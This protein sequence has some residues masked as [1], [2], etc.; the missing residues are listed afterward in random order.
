M[1]RMN[2]DG[3]RI[4]SKFDLDVLGGLRYGS[5]V[6]IVI[7]AAVFAV[8]TAL[9]FF[10]LNKSQ[11]DVYADYYRKM[12]PG[13]LA[14]ESVYSDKSYYLLDE[15]SSDES[16][17]AAK[18]AIPPVFAID[19]TATY[20]SLE[21]ASIL[22]MA[23]VSGGDGFLSKATGMGLSYE[24]AKLAETQL[25]SNSGEFGALLV[26]MVQETSEKGVFDPIELAEKASGFESVNVTHSLDF[27]APDFTDTGFT[28]ADFTAGS[29]SLQPAKDCLVPGR[30]EAFVESRLAGSA[31]AVDAR[32][33]SA[34]AKVTA[35]IA[36]PNMRYNNLMTEKLR[37]QVDYED[38]KIY[39][40]LVPGQ[41]IVQENTI[42]TE[43][44]SRLLYLL[45]QT[46]S[47]VPK[48]RLAGSIILM[49][50]V[51]GVCLL[52]FDS[53]TRNNLHRDVLLIIYFGGSL[54]VSVIAYFM[55]RFAARTGLALF[56]AALPIYF[57][58]LLMSLLS[59]RR[60]IGSVSALLLSSAFCLLP[61]ADFTT[62]FYCMMSSVSCVLLI[63]FLIRRKDIVKQWSLMTAVSLVY[64]IVA[65][66]FKKSAFSGYL[67]AVVFDVSTLLL[68]FVAVSALLPLLENAF[69]IPTLFK[70]REMADGNSPI[71]ERLSQEAPGTY[72]H[73][74]AVADIAEAA[75]S[76]V[77]AN[78]LLVRVGA[79]YHD[80]GKIDHAE[81]FTENI[82]LQNP[83]VQNRHET[84]NHNLSVAIIKSHVKLG[85][86]KG[87]QLGLPQEVLDIIGN[88]HGNDVVTF[89]YNE[90]LR[91]YQENPQ[92]Y[93]EPKIEEYAYL[94]EPPQTPEQAIVMLSDC[95]E[96]ACRSIVKPTPNKIE[97][98][99]RMLLV[100]K[101]VGNQLN[102]C[103]MT[104]TDLNAVVKSLS[105]SLT[106]RYHSRISYSEEEKK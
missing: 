66:L 19:M 48:G 39:R 31:G 62:F 16:Y 28:D 8:G 25:A 43:E 51:T 77:G 92:Q 103:G 9:M 94:G 93:A 38:S 49:L 83:S 79:M 54:L 96:A 56:E 63:R 99:I 60:T 86:E 47:S 2:S 91:L 100:K 82:S 45:S 21:N 59:G 46:A 53:F 90:A 87:R 89:F 6:T 95:S 7:L 68:S 5:V 97:K 106:G 4:F 10:S 65:F 3:F 76:A 52:I 33:I 13:Y 11:S 64:L 98:M 36:T 34:I 26:Q 69:N 30:I 104:I 22:S 58:P 84:I 18:E 1:K 15:Q 32:R 20:K 17:A 29:I 27:T 35:V 72:S 105:E 74:M 37:S 23:L 40:S 67:I 80:I 75:A 85:V 42:I 14:S 71:L 73:S 102:G 78:A 70:L 24:V 12:Q 50:L 61:G 44:S 81:Y 57:M 41:I 55:F 101:I 88:H